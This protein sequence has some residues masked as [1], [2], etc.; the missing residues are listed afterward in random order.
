MLQSE[1]NSVIS[2]DLWPVRQ[3]EHL[4]IQQLNQHADTYKL[5]DLRAQL[6]FPQVVH[7]QS[8]AENSPLLFSAN[9]FPIWIPPTFT[10]DLPR[11]LGALHLLHSVLRA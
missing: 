4:V 10:L 2:Y 6:T 1:E 3:V 5:P 9:C 8:S 7:C 11:G